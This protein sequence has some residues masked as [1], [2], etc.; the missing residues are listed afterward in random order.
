MIC[1]ENDVV[2]EA[3]SRGPV[4]DSMDAKTV[5]TA[6]GVLGGIVALVEKVWKGIAW[7]ARGRQERRAAREDRAWCDAVKAYME[8]APQ[9][10]DDGTFFAYSD[11]YGDDQRHCIVPATHERAA[12]WGV[13]HGYFLSRRDE[14]GRLV[15]RPR[16]DEPMFGLPPP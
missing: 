4:A 6:I 16:I 13:E 8:G 2:V 14:D 7:V 15:I 1:D 10:P 12:A 5:I 11:E 9:Q 3:P